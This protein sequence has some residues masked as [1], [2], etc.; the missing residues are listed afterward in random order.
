MLEAVINISEGRDLDTVRGIGAAAGD[1]LLDVH[2]DADHHRSVLTIAGPDIEARALAVVSRAIAGIDLRTHL[3][4]H[5]RV[6]AV[7]VVPIVPIGEATMTDALA[8]RNNLA[9]AIA[10]FGV[11][12]FLYGPERSLP[13]IRRTAFTDLAPDYGPAQP[14]VTAGAACVGARP[15]LVAYNVWLEP[16]ATVAQAQAIARSLRSDAVRA[17]GLEVGGRAQVSCNLIAPSRVGPDAVVDSVALQAAV[18]GTELVGLI[19]AAVLESIDPARWASL[20]LHPSKTIEAR[21][22]ETGLDGGRFQVRP[23]PQ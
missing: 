14:H 5:P 11:P 12:V 1:H 22:R 2:S 10:D 6:G 4:V 8:V 3:G 18:A 17:L 16:A 7:D 20:D 21:L 9:R 13:N 15:L 19:P 23:E